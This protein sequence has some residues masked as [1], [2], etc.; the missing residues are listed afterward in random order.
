M[1]DSGIDKELAVPIRLEDTAG[2][3]VT[4]KVSGDL[5]VQKADPDDATWQTVAGGSRSL[6]E[7]GTG[8]YTLRINASVI[9]TKGFIRLR[10]VCTGCVTKQYVANIVTTDFDV[11]FKSTGDD[12]TGDGSYARPYKTLSQCKTH[13]NSRPG[14]TI[15]CLDVPA[16]VAGNKDQ[17]F[18]FPVKI[19]GNGFSWSGV[20][21]VTYNI[22]I[23]TVAKNVEVHGL[24]SIKIHF[25]PD[26]DNIIC[27]NCQDITIPTNAFPMNS[28]FEDIRIAAAVTGA[29]TNFGKGT[30]LRRVRFN[31]NV[32]VSVGWTNGAIV[33]DCIIIGDFNL[34]NAER[35]QFKNLSVTGNLTAPN[36]G[37]FLGQCILRNVSV[38]GTA[39]VDGKKYVFIGGVIRG[40]LNLNS[41]SVDCI[42]WNT[43]I[44][45][46]V[47]DGGT[48]N[49]VLNESEC[50]L[51]ATSQ[52]IKTKTDKLTFNAADK[53]HTDVREVN[54]IAVASPNDFKADVSALLT[55]LTYIDFFN[56]EVLTRDGEEPATYKLGTGG[57]AKT[58]D[59]DH[60]VIG[61][62]KK[63]DKETVL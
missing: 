42:F 35:V 7:L 27:K 56:K 30:T 23:T 39:T 40:A 15:H 31:G 52:A 28:L 2:A 48:G 34:G 63:A 19:M 9:D 10:V 57:G 44:K 58:I 3:D 55:K 54:D 6:D 16:N 51:E 36:N 12:T 29:G 33:E 43:R 22:G 37:A 20:A 59:V 60:V 62:K 4:G 17:D 53:L 1:Y 18:S 13:I 61:S 41:N 49:E 45:G 38:E 47:T 50:A 11:Y 46:A 8:D 25:D 26:A 24:K 21:P 32:T 14:F 5:T